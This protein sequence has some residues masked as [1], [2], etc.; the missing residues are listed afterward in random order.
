L[1]HLNYVERSRNILYRTIRE[2]VAASDDTRY[3]K[4]LLKATD[5]YRICFGDELSAVAHW[6][7]HANDEDDPMNFRACDYLKSANDIILDANYMQNTS[8]NFKGD[9]GTGRTYLTIVTEYGA[10]NLITHFKC[11][12]G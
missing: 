2:T 7:K 4:I 6:R 10:I 11:N 1:I 8:F 3:E 5:T 12:Q 9:N